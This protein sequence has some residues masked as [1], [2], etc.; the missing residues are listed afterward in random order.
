MTRNREHGQKV[1]INSIGGG[2]DHQIVCKNKTAWLGL[3]KENQE[4]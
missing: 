2:G 4:K 1:G 3:M